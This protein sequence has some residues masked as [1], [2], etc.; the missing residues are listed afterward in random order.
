MKQAPAS[1]ASACIG[2]H[3]AQ[4]IVIVVTSVPGRVR[5]VVV[6]PMQHKRRGRYGV[7]APIVPV[8]MLLGALVLL[9]AGFAASSPGLWLGSAILA[10][11]AASFLFTTLIGKFAVW[12]RLLGQLCLRGDEA[13]LDIGC[14]RGAVL[15][16]I[17]QLVPDGN[18]VGVDLWRTHDQ[19]GNAEDVTRQNAEAEGVA[20]RV[21]LRTADMRQLPFAPESFD[22]V[23]SSLAIHNLKEHD[24]RAKAISECVRVLRPGGQLVIADI[25][26]NNEYAA[27]L[28][29]LAVQDIRPQGF[30]WRGWFG[31][32]WM[33]MRAITAC[34]RQGATL[35]PA[36]QSQC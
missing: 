6:N 27:D 23:V 29:R 15:L 12:E 1:H 26:K 22:V 34:K 28:G 30:G 13:V 2:V 7:D 11:S 18:A 21:E 10:L 14:G 32:P 25:G 33:A 16:R 19:S 31:G 24:D 20:E 5:A 36:D 17:A 35:D 3:G 8:F 9:V 4:S